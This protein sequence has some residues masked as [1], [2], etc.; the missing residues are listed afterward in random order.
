[1]LCKTLQIASYHFKTQIRNTFNA[2]AINFKSLASR[3]FA[4]KHL[5]LKRNFSTHKKKHFKNTK[6]QNLYSEL[7][8]K[9][10]NAIIFHLLQAQ[11]VTDLKKKSSGA[12]GGT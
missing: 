6:V 10:T 12:G 9:F 2:D 1:M 7:F 5:L 11:H 4:A 8:D 3:T